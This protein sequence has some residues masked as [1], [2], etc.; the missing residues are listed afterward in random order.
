M[1]PNALLAEAI[2]NGATIKPIRTPGA[3]PESRYRPSDELAEFVRMRDC[4]PLP[5]L[6]RPRGPLRSRPRP[7]MA[8]GADACLESE[9]QMPK[10]PLDE[11]LLDRHRWLVGPTASR[12]TV[13][14]TAPSGAT[15]TTHP[16]SRL[17]FPTWDVT[18]AELPPPQTQ[19]PPDAQDAG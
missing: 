2:R 19:P 3:E 12:R 11:D 18:T 7:P 1:L 15:F 4:L 13:I 9:L 6:R 5:R 14:W 17:F 10:P 16:G 8:M